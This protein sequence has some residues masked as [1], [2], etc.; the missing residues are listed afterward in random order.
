MILRHYWVLWLNLKIMNLVC[1]DQQ[2]SYV[3]LLYKFKCLLDI[4]I[5]IKKYSKR[6][7]SQITL[8]FSRAR[9][10][11]AFWGSFQ[12]L[13]TKTLIW[14][15]RKIGNLTR[16][17]TKFNVCKNDCT[18]ARNILSFYL[19]YVNEIPKIMAVHSTQGRK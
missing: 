13:L 19:L 14:G 9:Y 10:A 2:K 11:R 6:D 4:S 16:K 8:K 18:C 3:Q 7:I 1:I 17:H 15:Y 5:F 12:H